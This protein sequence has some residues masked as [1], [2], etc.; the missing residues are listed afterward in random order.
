[1][2]EKNKKTIK[3]YSPEKRDYLVFLRTTGFKKN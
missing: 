2:G 1:M 3:D